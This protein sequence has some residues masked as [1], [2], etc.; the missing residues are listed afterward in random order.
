MKRRRRSRCLRGRASLCP[1]RRPASSRLVL[2]CF[3]GGRGGGRE[4]ASRRGRLERIAASPNRANG[5][6][7]SW[8]CFF[9]GRWESL[10]LSG[11]AGTRFATLLRCSLRPRK[12]GTSPSGALW[13]EVP[14]ASSRVS[15]R[16]ELEAR[17]PVES[18]LKF[19][20][21]T[22]LPFGDWGRSGGE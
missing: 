4:R 16:R 22:W 5:G 20:G 11:E 9:A 12:P 13:D 17:W 8:C 10:A 18:R 19:V 6:L 7:G 1:Q 2:L 15:K 3:T 21:D 14:V